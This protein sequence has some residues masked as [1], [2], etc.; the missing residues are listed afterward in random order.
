MIFYSNIPYK[1]FFEKAF[2]LIEQK[3]IDG[4]TMRFNEKSDY[5][6]CYKSEKYADTNRFINYYVAYKKV[7]SV[8]ID[9]LKK[10]GF[11][12][13]H[14]SIGTK[15]YYINPYEFEVASLITTIFYYNAIPL[16]AY[17][18]EI[19]SN[20][21]KYVLLVRDKFDKII[22]AYGFSHRMGCYFLI[23]D[24]MFPEHGDYTFDEAIN[25]EGSFRYFGKKTITTIEECI[26]SASNFSHFAD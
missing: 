20:I 7:K 8:Y 2:C 18:R 12:V 14:N 21:R 11:Y 1:Y 22:G 5:F 25:Y 4:Y 3:K 26:I 15:Y 17:Q 13:V 9:L 16:T 19:S 24:K 23:G 10:R 6:Y